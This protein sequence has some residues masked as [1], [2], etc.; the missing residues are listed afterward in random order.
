MSTPPMQ[1]DGLVHRMMIYGQIGIAAD[2]NSHLGE[3]D[4]RDGTGVQ[5]ADTADAMH[6]KRLAAFSAGIGSWRHI[7]L[8]QIGNVIASA[9]QVQ[10]RSELMHLAAVAVR[11]AEA[12]DR[13]TWADAQG[14]V[15][16]DLTQAADIE[17]SGSTR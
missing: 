7:V 6:D 16:A 2:M 14:N 11:W 3:S 13:R 4:Y 10:L 8:S 1:S 9:D 15:L 17:L 12:I 5:Y